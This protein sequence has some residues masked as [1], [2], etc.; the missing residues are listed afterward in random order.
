MALAGPYGSYDNLKGSPTYGWI[1]SIVK[2]HVILL[3][4]SS[5]SLAVDLIVTS[6]SRVLMSS[7]F[8]FSQSFGL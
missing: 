3:S 5:T 8:Q 4:A 2:T 6:H 7:Y 1:V